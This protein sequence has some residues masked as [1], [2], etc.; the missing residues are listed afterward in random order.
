MYFFVPYNISPIQQGIQAGHVALEYAHA[1][2]SSKL[3]KEFVLNHKTWIILNGGTT[4]FDE[5]D[6]GTMQQTLEQIK[7]YNAN[8]PNDNIDYAMFIEPDL[9]NAL[10][11]ICFICDERVWDYESYPTPEQFDPMEEFSSYEEWLDFVG[12]ERNL[13]L[14]EIIRTK[15][16]A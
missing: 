3:F 6:P 5:V 1:H 2:G 7:S 16:L 4:R 14:R 15:K 10:S 9:N 11:G 13:F 8:H 12:G